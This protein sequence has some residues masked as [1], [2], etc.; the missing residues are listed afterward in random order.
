VI[1]ISRWKLPKIPELAA[2]KISYIN[3]PLLDLTFQNRYEAPIH[4]SDTHITP[5]DVYF[6]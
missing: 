2:A 4:K 1:N 5:N 3:R 6:T